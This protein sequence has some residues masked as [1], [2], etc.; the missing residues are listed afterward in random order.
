V[1][2]HTAAHIPAADQPDISHLLG[3]LE[4][5]EREQEEFQHSEPD[6]GDGELRALSRVILLAD[7]ADDNDR[8]LDGASIFEYKR[9]GK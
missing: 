6:I 9:S 4:E 8:E 7:L 5:R 2:N 1:D 3:A